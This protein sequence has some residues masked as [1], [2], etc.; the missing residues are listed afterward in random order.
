MGKRI[1]NNDL[2]LPIF[3]NSAATENNSMI[4][5]VNETILRFKTWREIIADII[6]N[7]KKK[8]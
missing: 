7:N 4:I 5:I 2:C 6:V 3:Q 8:Y 1:Q